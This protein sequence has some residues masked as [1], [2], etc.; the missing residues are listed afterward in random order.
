MMLNSGYKELVQGTLDFY[1]G[2]ISCHLLQQSKVLYLKI[3]MEGLLKKKH[4]IIILISRTDRFSSS[5][6]PLLEAHP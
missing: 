1:P 4:E 2:L 5:F 3:F 6:S